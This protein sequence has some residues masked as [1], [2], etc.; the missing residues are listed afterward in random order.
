[1][2]CFFS[3]IV[4]SITISFQSSSFGEGHIMEI[5]SWAFS[6]LCLF[7]SISNFSIMGLSAFFSF[8]FKHSEIF[9]Y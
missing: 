9:H 6:V 2:L 5:V 7:Y 4:S 3:L 8:R 1:V